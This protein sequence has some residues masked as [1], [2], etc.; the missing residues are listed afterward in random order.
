MDSLVFGGADP[1]TDNTANCCIIGPGYIKTLANQPK[2]KTRPAIKV[3]LQEALD[4]LTPC[5]MIVIEFPEAGWLDP[6]RVPAV[7]ST[8]ESAV[9][10]DERLA[11]RAAP[12]VLKTTKDIDTALIGCHPKRE[13]DNIVKDYLNRELLPELGYSPDEC[14]ALLAPRGPL[15]NPD[16]RAAGMAA[17]LARK[18]YFSQQIPA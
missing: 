11:R 18:L 5:A 15:S 12:S 8:I 16:K 14:L 13:A 7:F 1:S 10:L 3:S 17:L 6:L 9:R 2:T 4:F